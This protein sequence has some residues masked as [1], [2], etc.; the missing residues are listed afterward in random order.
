MTERGEVYKCAMCGN[1]VEVLHPGAGTLVCCGEPMQRLEE[2]TADSS[3]EKH[4]PVISRT[5][6]GY[7][8]KVGSVPHPMLDAHF[9]E[10]IE[11]SADGRT[12]RAFLS[13][14]SPP[15]ALFPGPEASVVGARE[16][17]NIHGLWKG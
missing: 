6:D 14:G 13:P 9:I 15:E 8:V 11:F 4:V 12:C 1:V 10:W 3:L 17:C 5:A 7:L 16:F 2:Q